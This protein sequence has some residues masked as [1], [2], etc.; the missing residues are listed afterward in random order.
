MI[1]GGFVTLSVRDRDRAVRFYVETLGMK[2]VE[3]APAWALIDAGDGLRIGLSVAPSED[4]SGPVAANRWIGLYPKIPLD[5]AI[6]IL[7]NRGVR[8]DVKEAGGRTSAHFCDPDG[9]ALAVC[10]AT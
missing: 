8:F 3:E 4:P 2:L 9:N 1:R 10:V 7:E 6:A 5:E